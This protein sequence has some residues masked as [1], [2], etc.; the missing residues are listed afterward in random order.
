[1][2]KQLDRRQLLQLA[3]ALGGAALS[4]R[5]YAAPRSGPRFVLVFLRGGYDAA[6]LLIP[7]SSDFY[8][9]ARPTIAIARPSPAATTDTAGAGAGALALDA[10]WALAPA[11]RDT[12]GAL[13]RQRQVAFIP[14]AGTEDLSRSHFETQDSIELGQ[15]LDGV[16]NYRSGFMARLAATLTAQGADAA[17]I[18]FTDAL[19]LS[20]AGPTPI[21]NVSLKRVDRP[22][23]DERQSRI[24]AQ[25]YAGTPLEPAVADG[26]ALRTQ[27][28]A[29]MAGIDDAA[30]KQRMSAEM[31]AAG[32]NAVSG[33]AFEVQAERMARL[34][35]DDYRIGFVDVG[36]WDTHVNEGGTEGALAANL[37]GLG[38]GLSAFAGALGSEWNNTVVVV[39]S[40][41]GRTFREN[42]DRGTDHGHGSVYWVLGGAV[43]GGRIAGEQQRV[44][45]ETLFQDRDYAVLNDYRAVL[46][47]LFRSLWQL[48]PARCAQVFPEV[49]PLD[50][51]LV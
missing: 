8:Y 31:I 39:L 17:P 33:A 12:L 35:R 48:S 25:M 20:F 30:R 23:F 44:A 7:Y 16:R 19:P 22:S 47:G 43:A 14:F 51:K 13:Y 36:G 42:G 40:E 28:A 5:L 26:L 9:E 37:N 27:V 1:M 6:N 38:R 46:G 45:R 2:N 34:M 24:L 32:R 29:E 10:D 18:A 11:L 49:E 21:A 15:P 3:A 4:G 41:F 50:L